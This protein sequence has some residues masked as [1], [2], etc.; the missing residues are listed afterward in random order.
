MTARP[1][2]NVSLDLRLNFGRH[3]GL[4][5]GQVLR[6]NLRAADDE[7]LLDRT[8]RRDGALQGRDD[9]SAIGVIVRIAANDDV[10]APR[11]WAA[12][13]FQHFPAHNDGMPQRIL[14]EM[15]QIAW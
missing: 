10:G 5:Q 4:G 6:V 9:D 1:E 12:Q 13:G 8:T 14:L 7:R 2:K 3:D 11:Q 15:I